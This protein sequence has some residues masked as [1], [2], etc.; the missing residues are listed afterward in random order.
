MKT[1]KSLK[2]QIT[3]VFSLALVVMAIAVCAPNQSF[4]NGKGRAANT[5]QRNT[6]SQRISQ[7]VT[8]TGGAVKSNGPVNK[9]KYGPK[10]PL[11]VWVWDASSGTYIWM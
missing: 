5:R 2:Q 1:M 11:G 4:A 6:V 9:G 8:Q 10:K 3:T 7:P